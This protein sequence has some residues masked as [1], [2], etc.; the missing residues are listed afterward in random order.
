LPKC[1]NQ[2]GSSSPLLVHVLYLGYLGSLFIP[3]YHYICFVSLDFLF[4]K[5]IHQLVSELRLLS[6]P[7]FPY[8]N[9]KL[10]NSPN[11]YPQKNSQ[12]CPTKEIARS[13]RATPARLCLHSAAAPPFQQF[14]TARPCLPARPCQ[15]LPVPKHPLSNPKPLCPLAS[16]PSKWPNK[17]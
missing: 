6:W 17:P 13:H 1:A 15:P 11:T 5:N 7:S 12:P 10:T 14:S 4:F 2:G 3:F 16:H 9:T 8:P